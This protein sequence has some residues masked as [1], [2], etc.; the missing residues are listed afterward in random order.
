MGARLLVAFDAA[1]VRFHPRHQFARAE[2]LG[3]VIVAADFEAQDAVHF[4]GAGRQEQHG[5]AR[6]NGGLADLAAQLEAVGIG[7]HDV[8]QDQVGLP[9]FQLFQRSLVA[10]EDLGQVTL[11]GQIVFE[12]AKPV[13]PR[14]RQ[15]RSSSPCSD[16]HFS[17][18]LQSAA[19]Q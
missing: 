17:E 4:I 5:R 11:A 3:H 2:G 6:Q 15:L 12:Q 8:Q 14:P 1:Q 9:V 16:I 18:S 7:Q 19:A 10:R 13:P